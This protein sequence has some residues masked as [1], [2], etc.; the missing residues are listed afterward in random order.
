[1]SESQ[2]KEALNMMGKQGFF[3]E[4]T[5][6]A[7]FAGIQ[8]LIDTNQIIEGQITVGVITGNGLK[9][10]NTLQNLLINAE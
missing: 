3:I 8:T 10:T 5:S 4:P 2:I 6:A 7:A 9:S 1:M